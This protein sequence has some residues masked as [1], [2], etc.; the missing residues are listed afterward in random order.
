MPCYDSRNDTSYIR[1]ECRIEEE[2][3]NSLLCSACR[4]LERNKYDFEENP[5]LSEWWSEH[6]KQD[7]DREK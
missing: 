6:K 5:R 7:E 4:V 2:K 1:N 3:L